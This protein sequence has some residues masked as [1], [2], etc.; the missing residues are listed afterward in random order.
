MSKGWSATARRIRVPVGFVFAAAF[1][2]FSH[3]RWWSLLAGATLV[4]PALGLRAAASGHVRKDRRLTTS[5]PYAYTRNPLYLGSA[6]LA[7]GFA[8]ASANWWI[9]L[10]TAVLFAALYL[11]T[12]RSEEQ[13]LRATFPEF[14][15]YEK[16]V[17]RLVPRLNAR[18]SAA[19]QESQDQSSAGAAEAV[20]GH[21]VFS[22]RLYHEH[23]EYE[24]ALGS[25]LMLA[26][27][28][29]KLLWFNH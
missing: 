27:L 23:R 10:A 6:M 12:I 11:P 26:A 28:I 25:A 3:P 19:S 13:Y 2:R 18:Q 16:E 9:A 7:A 4:L 21:A 15:G 1:L 14:A 5:G 24:A 8:L 22:W 17:P 29:A 20:A